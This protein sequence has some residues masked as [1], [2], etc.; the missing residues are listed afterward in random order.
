MARSPAAVR[1]Q[2][3]IPAP[4]QKDMGALVKAKAYYDAGGSGRRMAAWSPGLAGPNRT[5]KSLQAIRNRSRDTARNDWAGRRSGNQWATTLIGIGIRAHFDGIEDRARRKAVQGLFDRFMMECDADGSS[6]LFGMQTMIVKAWFYAGEVF[7]RERPRD[8][9]APLTVPVQFQMLE[10]EMLPQLTAPSWPGMPQGNR[11]VQGIELNKYDRRIAYWFY[12]SHPGEDANGRTPSMNDLV[13]V[14]ADEVWHVYDPERPGLLRGIPQLTAVLA[15]LRT[16]GDFEDST[17]E[18]QRLANLFTMFITKQLPSE[19]WNGQELDSITGMPKVWNGDAGAVSLEPGAGV[20]LRPGE[21]VKFANPPGAG[22]DY[23]DFM[24]SQMLGTAAGA[25]IPYELMTGD[26][27]EVSDR[28][29]RVILNEFQRLAEQKQ[30]QIVI[31]K[32][33]QKVVESFAKFARLRGLLSAAEVDKVRACRHAPHAWAYFHPV[34]DVQGK[35]LEITAG[36]S[37]RSEA[38]LARGNDP[39]E[40]DEQRAADRKREERLGLLEPTPAQK[41]K[42]QQ[43]QQAQQKAA[44]QQAQQAQQ[45]GALLAS[46]AASMGRAPEAQPLNITTGGVVVNQAAQPAPVVNVEP[47]PVNVAAPVVNVAAPSVNVEPAA[48]NV[49]VE[50]AAV[51]VESPTVHVDV[52]APIVNVQPAEVVVELPERETTSTIL[53]DEQGQIKSVR[54]VERTK[55]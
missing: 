25:D 28:V 32:F 11:M 50:P 24:R 20:E 34:Q 4:E 22:T 37:S 12:K 9:G 53:R 33:C 29:L 14:P 36:I 39:D 31:P 18:R 38:I 26:L 41:A 54:Q 48:V 45:Y 15:R 13:R 6:V 52:P 43:G 40:V 17:L 35:Q 44:Q 1:R 42:S 16:T 27:R 3:L 19:F 21:D 5:L 7:V 46:I 51:N 49:S 23:A 30:W 10:A 47:T 2:N 8:F 55:K